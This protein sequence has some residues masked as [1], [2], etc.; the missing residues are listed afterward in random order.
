MFSVK[1]IGILHRK[2][3]FVITVV[4]HRPFFAPPEVAFHG[5]CLTLELGG[6]LFCSGYGIHLYVDLSGCGSISCYEQQ[7]QDNSCSGGQN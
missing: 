2:N 1:C 3:R 4:D 7:G 5:N 6:C